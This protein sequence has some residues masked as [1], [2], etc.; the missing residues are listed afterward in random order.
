MNASPSARDEAVES[1]RVDGRIRL[2]LAEANL[3]LREHVARLLR[4]WWNIETVGDGGAAVEAIRQRR[5]TLVLA[6][7]AMPGPHGIGLL[8]A[9][10]DDPA[11]RSIPI[12]VL[13]R[14]GTSVEA[15]YPNDCLIKPFSSRELIARVSARL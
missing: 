2:L 3:D 12:I 9:L 14:R 6:D 11:T 4:R 13:S 1:A 7:A 10:R 8:H 5:P 15:P